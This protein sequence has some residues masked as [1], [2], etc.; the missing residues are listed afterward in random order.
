MKNKIKAYYK[1]LSFLPNF[2][3]L[4]VN[5]FYFARKGLYQG[6]KSFSHH[7]KGK[8]LDVGCGQK[9]YRSLFQV[10]EYIGMDMKDAGNENVNNEIDVYYD[11]KTF[12][13]EDK[14]FDSVLCNQVFEHVFNPEEFL[15]EINRVTKPDGMLLMTVPFLWDE[16]SQPYDYARYSSFG[17]SHVITKHGFE[18]MEFR[19]SVNDIRVIFQ[20]INA[21]IFKKTVTK[22]NYINLLFSLILMTPFNIIGEV[23][24][25]VL[26]RNDDLYLDNIVI[27]K[28]VNHL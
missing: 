15:K 4:F 22:S 27:A 17:L 18:I 11:G 20:L 12:P 6:I 14:S 2:F 25:F 21:Y 1:R 23:F 13:F 10:S 19:K 26:P 9:P 16:H 3:S 8:T 28:K 24:S 7:I 5:P